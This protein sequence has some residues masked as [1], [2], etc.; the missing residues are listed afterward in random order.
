MFCFQCRLSVI[1]FLTKHI[2]YFARYNNTLFHR[3]EKFCFFKQVYFS[4]LIVWRTIFPYNFHSDL[5]IFHVWKITNDKYVMLWKKY[6]YKRMFVGYLACCTIVMER[7]VQYVWNAS[8]GWNKNISKNIQ[9]FHWSFKLAT[10]SH[11]MR[12]QN[13]ALILVSFIQSI[14]LCGVTSFE[15]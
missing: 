2:L 14:T 1:T 15:D 6:W 3:H 10:C 4:K 11:K 7:V 12:K 8:G 5:F 9:A 13:M